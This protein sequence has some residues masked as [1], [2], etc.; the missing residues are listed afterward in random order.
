MSNLATAK[1][2]IPLMGAMPETTTIGNTPVVD[3]EVKKIQIIAKKTV[4][5]LAVNGKITGVIPQVHQKT[6]AVMINNPKNLAVKTGS[7]VMKIFLKTTQLAVNGSI[8][9]RTITAIRTI[10]VATM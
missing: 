6:A 7:V 9:T 2:D 3:R 5:K 8:K 4:I 10:N 1:V